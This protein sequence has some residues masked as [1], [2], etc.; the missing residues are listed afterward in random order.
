MSNAI[1]TIRIQ[2]RMRFLNSTHAGR[3]AFHHC[4]WVW[5]KKEW[6]A[7]DSNT[8]EL[9]STVSHVLST[10]MSLLASLV[11]NLVLTIT[12]RADSADH[13]MFTNSQTQN[14]L[15]TTRKA[16]SVDASFVCN[17]L[18]YSCRSAPTLT[19]FEQSLKYSL[20]FHACSLPC[21]T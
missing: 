8:M 20:F 4:V 6:R 1:I 12:F 13:F 9:I 5:E 3:R 18:F 14:R 11:D 10:V 15:L 16:F 2:K 7:Y 21:L 17:S 19:S